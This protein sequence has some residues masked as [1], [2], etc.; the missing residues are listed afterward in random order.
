MNRVRKTL[1]ILVIAIISC[2]PLSARA[3]VMSEE[4]G[5][6][7]CGNALVQIGETQLQV[8][9]ECGLPDARDSYFGGN[10][11]LD[12]WT[13]NRGPEDFIYVFTF[14]NGELKYIKETDRG[15]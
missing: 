15:F 14:Y 11:G 8:M 12:K 6:L 9:H 1:L 2:F 5:S 10:G 7:R 13:Y 3:A 4:L